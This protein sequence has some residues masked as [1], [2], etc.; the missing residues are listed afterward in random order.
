[1]KTQPPTKSS[2]QDIWH[3]PPLASSSNGEYVIYM[4]PGNPC[5]MTYYQ[6]FLS[7]L[8]TSINAAL[9]P[10]QMSAHVGGYT[11]PGFRMS[12]G[13]ISEVKLP[14]SLQDQIGYAEKLI[15]AAIKQHIKSA[16]RP[17]LILV[18]HSIG[19][20]MAL[21][22]LRRY[23]DGHSTLTHAD[24]IGAVLLCP[25]IIQMADAENEGVADYFF[26]IPGFPTILGTLVKIPTF[27]LSLSVIS[28]IACKVGNAPHVAQ[29]F[30]EFVKGP[31]AVRQ[32]MHLLRDSCQEVG[33]DKW[34]E[35]IWGAANQAENEAVPLKLYFAENDGWVS[36]SARD[37]L[38]AS[39]GRTE[40]CPWK[41]EMI[42]DGNG[43]GHGFNEDLDH[44]HLVAEK[45]ARMIEEFIEHDTN[46]KHH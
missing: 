45:V 3:K 1:M 35:K 13:H 39:R 26:R 17:K 2:S 19:T 10:R 43:I 27:P 36:R 8:F 24:I 9:S 29:A 38:I 16:S 46:K 37:A 44:S 34:T 22:I 4:L 32:T 7:T 5:I 23:K 40:D 25:T 31:H 11:P 6:P 20:Y 21:E 30:A 14:A 12:P 18:A 42:V 41:P 33:E 15:D 28:W